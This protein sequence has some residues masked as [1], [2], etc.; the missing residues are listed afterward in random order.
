MLT[1]GA[2]SQ[3]VLGDCIAGRWFN[4]QMHKN[5]GQLGWSYTQQ[6]FNQTWPIKQTYCACCWAAHDEY[7]Q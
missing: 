3:G 1:L 5:L 6:L 4:A 7:H 2:F